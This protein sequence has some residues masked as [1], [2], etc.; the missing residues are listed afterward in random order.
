MSPSNRVL[1]IFVGVTVIFGVYYLIAN[2]FC[3]SDAYIESILIFAAINII[4]SLSFYLP[5]SA[6]LL[7]LAQAGF[8]GVGAYTSATVTTLWKFKYALGPIDLTFLI[9]LLA[10][11]VL[12]TIVGVI[13]AF[14]ALRI[15]GIYLLLMTLAISEIIRVFFL[16]F[17]Y[18]GGASGLGGIPPLT[19]VWNIYVVLA[20]IVFFFIRVTKSRVGR[21]FE[22][23]KADED[24][25]EVMGVGLTRHKIMAFGTGAFIAGIGGG[26]YAHY[27]LYIDSTNFGVFR[28]IEILI[29]TLLGGYDIYVGPIYGGFFLTFMPEWLRIIQ[30]WR[31]IIFGSLLILMMIVRPSGLLS[32]EMITVRYWRAAVSK[33]AEG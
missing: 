25:A 12:A 10:G 9:A 13:T 15:R 7:S 8:M 29:F 22:A 3:T 23:M 28:S 33:S 1:A 6:G 27:A 17:E 16:N 21:A 11:G 4:L 30:D 14:P 26:L 31:I 18:T 24:A 19:T 20:I 5:S 2:L 32:K